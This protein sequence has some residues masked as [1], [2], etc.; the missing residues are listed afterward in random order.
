MGV[1]TT[2]AAILLQRHC[3]SHRPSCNASTLLIQL[4]TSPLRINSQDLKPCRQPLRTKQWSQSQRLRLIIMNTLA[5]CAAILFMHVTWC[6]NSYPDS[7]VTEVTASKE[8]FYFLGSIFCVLWWELM[9][10]H[11]FPFFLTSTLC[12][13]F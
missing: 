11:P 1:I 6:H 5:G 3:I 4:Q 13:S 7:C 9:P 12:I 8:V 10:L 2:G